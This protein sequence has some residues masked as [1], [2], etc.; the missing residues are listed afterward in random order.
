MQDLVSVII[1]VYNGVPYIYHS[2]TSVMQQ[3]YQN[4]E[5]II[6]NDGSTDETF[7]ICNRYAKK[8]TRIRVYNLG[9]KGV[10]EARNL[11]IQKSHG[12][13]ITFIDAD[14]YM[15]ATL[16]EQ[17]VNTFDTFHKAG[18]KPA[19]VMCGMRVDAPHTTMDSADQLVEEEDRI[20]LL[21]RNRIPYLAW[22]SLFNFV[23]NKCYRAEALKNAELRF[24]DHMQIGEDLCFNIR[25]LQAVP[26]KIAMINQP[27]YHYIRRF[28]HTLSLRY[29][30]GAVEDTKKVYLLFIDFVKDLQGITEDDILVVKSL[31][32][33]DWVSR[34]TAYY[35]D[36]KTTPGW[37]ARIRRV[38]RE[39]RSEEFTT[40]LE[41][42]RESEKV[43]HIRYLALRTKNFFIF[44]RMR[45]LYRLGIFLR[46]QLSAS[47]NRE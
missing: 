8:D 11:G 21:E 16:I 43:S 7:E 31:Y 36:R 42:V 35:E 33:R 41:A 32:L 29:Y 3:N 23:T 40:L 15:E 10:S 18:Q 37:F 12:T 46:K 19:F 14:D 20:L 22:R 30:P 44:Y 1:P 25:Y 38:N 27:V 45:S 17:Y 47:R 13:Y 9:H 5:I 2:I 26:G 6:I 24:T 34:L 4:I 28:D 39:I